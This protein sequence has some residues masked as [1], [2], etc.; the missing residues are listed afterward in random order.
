VAV[1]AI[2]SGIPL[3]DRVA[4]IVFEIDDDTKIV[5]DADNEII[6]SRDS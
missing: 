5:V 6:H 1:G 2:I 3:V 4:E